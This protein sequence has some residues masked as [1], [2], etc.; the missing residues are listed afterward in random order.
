[1]PA[2]TTR[3]AAIARF[4]HNRVVAQP[5]NLA[6][7]QEAFLDVVEEVSSLIRQAQKNLADQARV[8]ARAAVEQRARLQA[9][10]EDL[11]L[12]TRSRLVEDRQSRAAA[13]ALYRTEAAR[14]RVD[15]A[16]DVRRIV[17]ADFGVAATVEEVMPYDIPPPAE[18]EFDPAM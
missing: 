16:A 6:R 8:R 9:F 12:K 15:L 13:T 11:A 18:A 5:S 14:H 3:L 4:R 2:R 17:T 1:M 10:R 7:R